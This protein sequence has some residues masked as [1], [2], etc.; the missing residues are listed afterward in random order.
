MTKK[1]Q[2]E[3]VDPT[4]GEISTSQFGDLSRFRSA[5][6]HG[7]VRVHK[8]FEKPSRTKQEFKEQ[9]DVNN[10]VANFTKTGRLDGYDAAQAKFLNLAAL[11]VSYHDALNLVISAREAFADL[12]A[13]ARSAYGNDVNQFLQAAYENPEAVFAP[14]PN[15]KDV[16]PH[17]PAT[18]PA[19]KPAEPPA[20]PPVTLPIATT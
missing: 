5:Y 19:P 4:T 3:T 14:P 7:S 20:T 1:T 16:P 10:I 17:V 8:T 13:D 15:L 2:T 11:P 9:C 18:T 6:D 12:P